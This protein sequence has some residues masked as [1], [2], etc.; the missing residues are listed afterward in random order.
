MLW[1]AADVLKVPTS[2]L[3]REGDGLGGLRRARRPRAPDAGA[4]RPS[5]GAE[6]EVLGGL[7]EGATVVLY[8]GDAASA[9]GVRVT[10]R[11]QE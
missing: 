4:A 7:A 11:V 6:A 9:D 2:A 8:P 1:E 10:P 3:F 5:H